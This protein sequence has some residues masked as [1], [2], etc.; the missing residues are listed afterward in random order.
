MAPK[1]VGGAIVLRASR[2]S[3]SSTAICPRP[4]AG[5]T[6]RCRWRRD[7]SP[8]SGCGRLRSRRDWPD[9]RA[10]PV[11]RLR[12]HFAATDDRLGCT[13]VRWIESGIERHDV[14]VRQSASG[15]EDVPTLAHRLLRVDRGPEK[16]RHRECETGEGRGGSSHVIPVAARIIGP[17][18]LFRILHRFIAGHGRSFRKALRAAGL[19][20]RVH[21]ELLP[22][23][24][25]DELH[26]QNLPRTRRESAR[27]K[28]KPRSRKSRPHFDA[29]PRRRG[30]AW[31]HE[32]LNA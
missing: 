11:Q 26:R 9:R 15:R 29:G 19:D 14:D 24:T 5:E 23:A 28:G 20:V 8:R 2:S 22:Q 4:R 16:D 1:C 13:V 12:R 6:R 27:E 32:T 10:T 30:E 21:D 7:G 25:Q 18:R 31:R 3:T 17:L